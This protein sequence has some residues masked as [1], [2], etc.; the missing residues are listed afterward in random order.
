MVG[1]KPNMA[2][3]ASEQTKSAELSL[4]N[5]L[6]GS[7]S[8]YVSYES[9][10]ED[11]TAD[12]DSYDLMQVAQWLFRNGTPRLCRWPESQT[13]SSSSASVTMHAIVSQISVHMGPAAPDWYQGAMS[14]NMNHSSLLKW[15][16]S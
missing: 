12:T 7:S 14:W 8:P 3:D 11:K 16:R 9:R 5:E 15:P 2:S 10:Q 6:P 1:R 4:K 13:V